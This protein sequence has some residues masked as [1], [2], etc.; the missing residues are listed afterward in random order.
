MYSSSLRDSALRNTLSPTPYLDRTPHHTPHQSSPY[1]DRPP[2]QS[3]DNQIL[4][5]LRSINPYKNTFPQYST[6]NRP[7]TQPNPDAPSI[8]ENHRANLGTNF[9]YKKLKIKRANEFLCSCSEATKCLFC[10]AGNREKFVAH[11]KA[12]S[13]QIFR[14]FAGEIDLSG[15]NGF[16][17]MDYQNDSVGFFFS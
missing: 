10:F 5:E 15:P 4:A 8:G 11:E 1:L 16:T 7:L 3:T 13:G 9:P 17:N 2:H 14:D 12:I 6:P